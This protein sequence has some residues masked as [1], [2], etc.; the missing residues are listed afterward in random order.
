MLDLV[1]I[2]RAMRL[3][4]VETAPVDCRSIVDAYPLTNR[5]ENPSL[6]LLSSSSATCINSLAGKALF[7]CSKREGRQ[8]KSILDQGMDCKE[9]L[10]RMKL[11]GE[12]SIVFFRSLLTELPPQ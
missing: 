9:D 2:V 7:T 10:H 1:M 11:H 8:S 6:A 5:F 3:G 12:F 4:S